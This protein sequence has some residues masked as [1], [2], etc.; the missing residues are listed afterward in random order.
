MQTG[1]GAEPAERERIGLGARVVG[2]LTSPRETFER[3]MDDP[4]WVGILA[5][6]VGCTAVLSAA[7]LTADF[8]QRALLDQQVTTMVSFGSPVPDD[9]RAEL[10]QGVEFAA[11]AAF[12]SILVGAPI[13]TLILAGLLY[14]AGYGLLGAE[15]GFGRIF[16]VVAHT[17]VVSAAQQ[18]FVV[19]LNYARESIE[20]PTTLAAFAP[21]LDEETFAYKLLA[22]VD[23]FNVWWIMILSIG[24]AV[25]WKRRTAP[26]AVTL[27]GIF[28]GIVLLTAVLRTNLG[29]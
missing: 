10:R 2:V 9:V 29:F 18:F 17:G 15:A 16:S 26:V 1:N 12:G 27:Y 14:G 19:P 21:M 22:S 25:A 6:S 4:R 11:Y 13:F 23:L 24:L 20:P 5:L 7:L 8:A 3:V 28:A